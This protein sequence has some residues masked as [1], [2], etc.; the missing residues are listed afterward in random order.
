MLFTRLEGVSVGNP[1]KVQGI[2]HDS[3]K[4]KLGFWCIQENE[5]LI[6]IRSIPD[7][8]KIAPPKSP[9]IYQCLG[10]SHG[11]VASPCAADEWEGGGP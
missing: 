2:S 11:N 5:R 7:F 9:P 10:P 6:N 1:D 3:P 4:Q 8:L